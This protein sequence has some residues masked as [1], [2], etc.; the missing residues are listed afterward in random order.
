MKAA[1]QGAE[2]IQVVYNS[3][4]AVKVYR[5][6]L[7]NFFTQIRNALP[8]GFNYSINGQYQSF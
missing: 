7:A 5:N 4:D 1:P 3:E 2:G 6:E 8:I